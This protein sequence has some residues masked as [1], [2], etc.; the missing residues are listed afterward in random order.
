MLSDCYAHG[1]CQQDLF[2]TSDTMRGN[3]ALMG[4]IDQINQQM[5]DSLFFAS[6]GAKQS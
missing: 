1:V 6:K 2:V 4:L 3:S 5:P